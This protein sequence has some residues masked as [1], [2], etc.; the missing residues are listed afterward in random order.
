MVTVPELVVPGCA[1]VAVAPVGRP[2]A[3]SA[4]LPVKFERVRVAVVVALPPWATDADVGASAM[5]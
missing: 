4:T 3:A 1:Y 5:V 2:V